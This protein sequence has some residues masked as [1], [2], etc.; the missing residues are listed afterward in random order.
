MANVQIPNLP[1]ALALSGDESLEIVQA[2]VSVRATTSQM[3]QL[4]P[5][6]P[7]GPKGDTGNTGP[8]GAASTVP[9]P[10]GPKGDKG[11]TGN[12]GPQGP[13]GIQ[14]T[15]GAA[16]NA[17]G[18]DGQIQYNNGGTFNGFVTSGDGTLVRASLGA[19]TLTVTKTGGVNFGP[20]A[21]A[22]S[23]PQF[24]SVA[25]GV[26]P[27]SGGGAVNFMRADGV[28]AAPGGGGA[29]VT[30][31]DTAP[32]APNAGALWWESDTGQSYIYYNDGNTSQWVSLI[33]TPSV[34]AQN[35]TG[36]I[37]GTTGAAGVSFASALAVNGA[38]AT[39]ATLT[40]NKPASGYQNLIY[41]KTAGA[42]RWAVSL[43]NSVVESSGSGSDFY[44]NRYNDAG[45]Y[46]DSPLWIS[47]Q[48]GQATFTQPI[49]APGL[50]LRNRLQNGAFSVD[51]YRTYAGFGVVDTTMMCDRWKFSSVPS[52]SKFNAQV[53]IS[54]N[55]LSAT[56]SPTYLNI[57]GVNAYAVGA[58]DYF[59]ISQ[60]I[61]GFNFADFGFGTASAKSVVVSFWCSTN[62]TGLHSGA[63]RNAGATRSYP[64]TFTVPTANVWARYTVTIPGDTAGT[65][66]GFS[67]ASAA[68]LDFSLGVGTTYSG[69]AGAWA[70]VN[71]VAAT[72]AV[73][74]VQSGV[75]SFSITC[76][77][78]EA[79]PVATPFEIRDFDTELRKCMRYYQ[80]GS[81]VCSQ[82]SQASGSAL[83][84]PL[85]FLAPMRAAPTSIVLNPSGGGGWASVVS[86]GAVAGGFSLQSN[87]NVIGAVAFNY[88]YTASAEF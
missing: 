54:A 75:S 78:L 34:S 10:Q 66:V 32:V 49:N 61:E 12:T 5:A 23:L 64:F 70:G 68:T 4:A 47:R 43:G 59:M 38:A 26:V 3:G 44:I 17:G 24:T 83:Y 18:L 65:W 51:Q 21:T 45:T 60:G 37:L 22:T 63:L 8:Q 20:Y 81:G 36:L 52:T 79:G 62:V 76:V 73:S 55:S 6:G 67:N 74:V 41:G 58:G 69:P 57:V 35:G 31:S 25:S 13:Q 48:T 9:G 7:Q 16:G 53:N 1:V 15:P 56:G 80:T 30:I 72:G 85:N 88:T 77:Q 86:V 33:A 27:A 2:G 42:N 46:L 28:W 87:S 71:Y 82:Y 11:D 14:G 29:S 40:L 19:F 84:N 50:S 39:D